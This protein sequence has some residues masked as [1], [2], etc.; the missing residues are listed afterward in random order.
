MALPRLAEAIG[1]SIGRSFVAVGPLGGRHV[2]HLWRRLIEYFA[3]EIFASKR[4]S[5]RLTTMP[6]VPPERWRL[7]GI[8]DLEPAAWEALCYLGSTC[9]G[10]GPGA[11]KTE[12]LVQHATFLL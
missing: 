8:T 2:K 12:L 3:A 6:F 10:A 11:G 9:V 1:Y 5:G 7:A 4:G